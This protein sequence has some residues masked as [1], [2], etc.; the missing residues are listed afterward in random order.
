MAGSGKVASTPGEFVA[1][2]GRNFLA[3]STSMVAQRFLRMKNVSQGGLAINLVEPLHLKGVVA[4][5]FD[6]PSI[7]PRALQAKAD[8]VWSDSFE[9]GLRFLYIEKDSGVAL[10][11]WLDL[12]EAQCQFRVSTERA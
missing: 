4:V 12:L 8:V 1:C 6:I 9:M 11:S 5:E 10:K 3:A 2:A 7:E